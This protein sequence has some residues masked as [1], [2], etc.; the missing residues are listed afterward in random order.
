MNRTKWLAMRATPRRVGTRRYLHVSTRHTL[1]VKSLHPLVMEFAPAVQP[2]A[3][4]AQQGTRHDVHA[5]RAEAL[6]SWRRPPR[7]PGA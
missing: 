2:H 5:H 7:P 3:S 4:R 6:A 1:L